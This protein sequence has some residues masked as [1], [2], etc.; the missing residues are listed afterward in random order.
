MKT[1]TCKRCGKQFTPAIDGAYCSTKCE[2]MAYCYDRCACGRKKRGVSIRCEKC[3]RP[4][5]IEQQ[6]RMASMYVDERMSTHAIAALVGCSQFCVCSWLRKAGVTLR[7]FGPG[8]KTGR[9]AKV[10]Q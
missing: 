1:V 5:R 7:G 10:R 3:A 9:K 6:R 8:R 2:N 4:S